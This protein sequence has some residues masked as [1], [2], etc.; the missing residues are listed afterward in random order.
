MQK[1]TI[2]LLLVV[3]FSITTAELAWSGGDPSGYSATVGQTAYIPLPVAATFRRQVKNAKGK[4]IEHI[5]RVCNGK[6]KK[7]CGFWEDVNT[8]KKV[9]TGVTTYNKKNKRLVIKNVRE[10]DAGIYLT[11]NKN[12]EFQLFVY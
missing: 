5:Y 1:L 4:T 11:G 10:S 6:N 12:W 3:S 7:T 8:K 9:A 2:L